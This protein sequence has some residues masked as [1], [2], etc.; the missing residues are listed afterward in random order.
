[1][2]TTMFNHVSQPIRFF[3]CYTCVVFRRMV[4]YSYFFLF[5]KTI[6]Q[7]K[8]T[9]QKNY[10]EANVE[11]NIQ[12]PSKVMTR[13][14]FILYNHWSVFVSNWYINGS[15]IEPKPTNKLKLLFTKYLR[16][17]LPISVCLFHFIQFVLDFLFFVWFFVKTFS[18]W[19]FFTVS[20]F[21]LQVLCS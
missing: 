12:N 16:K 19:L 3:G 10:V 8:Q 2:S 20:V 14:F 15:W 1:M 21:H 6:V 11:K 18:V 5:V 9:S 13:K 7:T 17:T 4:T